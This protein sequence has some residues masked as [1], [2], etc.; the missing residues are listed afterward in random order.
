MTVEPDDHDVLAQ[1]SCAR[2][3]A[4]V[5]SSLAAKF[6][7]DNKT[8]VIAVKGIFRP[9][10]ETTG[11]SNV[12]GASNVLTI[13]LIRIATCGETECMFESNCTDVLEVHCVVRH[14]W[15]CTVTDGVQFASKKFV[16]RMCAVRYEVL[17]E[18]SLPKVDRTIESK[19]K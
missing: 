16:P 8:P 9:V 1:T 2:A 5:R 19:E 11:A 7:P 12:N 3:A 15:L 4:G 10:K 17:A 13:K 18:F 6:N 14:E